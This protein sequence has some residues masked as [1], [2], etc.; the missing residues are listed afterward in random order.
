MPAQLR[1]ARLEIAEHVAV[2]AAA[3][4]GA[5]RPSLVRERGFPQRWPPAAVGDGD[6]AE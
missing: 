6:G 4:P 2:R 1:L 3:R 5:L